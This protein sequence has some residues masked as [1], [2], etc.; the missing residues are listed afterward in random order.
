MIRYNP[1]SWLSLVFDVYSRYVIKSL[2]PTLLFFASYTLALCYFILDYSNIDF[3]GT[4]AFHST[5][6]V[7]L[8]LFLVLRTNTAYDRWWEGRI[9]WG[10]LVNDTRNLAIKVNSFVDEN[11]KDTRSFFRKM[12]PNVPV[13]IR[14]H[15]RDSVLI[16]E[17]DIPDEHLEEIK[18]S[19]HR[20][21][22]ICQLLFKR[23]NGLFKEGR[24]TGEQ[25]IIL[26]KE[27]KG[28]ID[29]LGACER[30]KATPIPHSYSMFIKKFIFL[31]LLTLPL[32]FI[33]LFE[34]WTIIV[35]ILTSYFLVS[36]EL[37]A[38]EIEDPFGNDI[39]DLPLNDL[40]VKI[41]GNVKELITI[42]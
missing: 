30:I 32:G 19:K 39:N 35:M 42:K 24:I 38:E 21:N 31:Y 34:Y 6:G 13:T 7:V 9:K 17:M 33:E 2:F 3:E 36:V 5:L 11:D 37:I 26:D 14:E 12:I 16:G 10:Q 1:K 8:G 27:L 20:P 41:K 23:V 4:L 40:S 22:I 15:L 29:I 28:F 25:F 18:Q